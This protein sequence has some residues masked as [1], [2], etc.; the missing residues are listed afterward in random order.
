MSASPI[1]L[2]D[3]NA[4]LALAWPPHR[5]HA[6]AHRWL[7]AR[8]QD[9]WVTRAFTQTAFVRLSCNPRAVTEAD[10]LSL[11]R[12]RGGRLATFDAGLSTL[13]DKPAERR[14]WI[15]VIGP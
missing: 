5:L 2:L 8:P 12:H 4:L 10:L 1:W 13:L 3:V 6:A 15:E 14:R 7:A 9:L 11:A